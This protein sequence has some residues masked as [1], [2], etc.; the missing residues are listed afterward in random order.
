MADNTEDTLVSGMSEET[1][2]S[3]INAAVESKQAKKSSTVGLKTPWKKITIGGVS[4]IMLGAGSAYAVEKFIINPD[5][6]VAIKVDDKQSFKEAFDTAHEEVGP[7]GVFKWQGNL[8]S[9]YDEKEWEAM[10]AEEQNKFN[11]KVVAYVEKDP[12][13]E[14]AD[15]SNDITEETTTTL[16]DNDDEASNVQIIGS[17]NDLADVAYSVDDQDVYVVDIDDNSVTNGQ[18]EDVTASNDSYLASLSEDANL[19]DETSETPSDDVFIA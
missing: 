16:A 2:R 15:T 18:N 5:L 7:G 6:K 10:P 9:T 14:D 11:E 1:M 8:Y 19:A 3:V 17:D 4:G 12:N 13:K